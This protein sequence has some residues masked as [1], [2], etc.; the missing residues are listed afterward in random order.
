GGNGMNAVQFFLE[1]YTTV[2][3]I[4]DEMV[5][6]G[7]SDDQLRHQPRADLNSLAWLLLH[8]SRW[9]HFALTALD[10]QHR[11]VLDREDWVARLNL[12]RRDVG[13]GMTTQECSDFN[14]QVDLT[15]LRA[16][17]TAVGERTR[18]R[19]EAM[20]PEELDETLDQAH[21]REVFAQGIVGNERAR[22][23]E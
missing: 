6:R 19:A 4:V 7:L 13:T 8:A 1:Q 21:L 11:Q 22:W 18:Q 9:E 5:F 15:A 2:R 12:S 3:L 20:R 14:T 17:W 23:V 16:Y 10:T